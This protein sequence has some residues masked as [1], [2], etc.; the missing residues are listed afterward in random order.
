M[1][2]EEF[3][4]H[5]LSYR[6]SKDIILVHIVQLKLMIKAHSSE[7]MVSNGISY[8]VIASVYSEK[9][10]LKKLMMMRIIIITEKAFTGK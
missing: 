9:T 8:V 5:T 7:R 1:G 4:W 10:H 3:K 2:R 6:A